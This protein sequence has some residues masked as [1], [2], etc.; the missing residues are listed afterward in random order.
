MLIG[1]WP[2]T[3]CISLR[4]T[5]AEGKGEEGEEGEEGEARDSAVRLLD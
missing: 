4:Q 3:S 5:G 2:T 1:R